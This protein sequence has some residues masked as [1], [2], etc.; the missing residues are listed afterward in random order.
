[1]RQR[2]HD[3]RSFSFRLESW[4][5]APVNVQLARGRGD[6]F[7]LCAKTGSAGNRRGPF[8]DCASVGD[9]TWINRLRENPVRI[10]RKSAR[11]CT[12]GIGIVDLYRGR[13][14]Y[15]ALARSVGQRLRNLRSMPTVAGSSSCKRRRMA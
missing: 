4:I 5:I 12:A 11:G 7:F 6:L 10:V 15:V 8:N 9:F 14:G 3:L 13:N 2:P 1:M